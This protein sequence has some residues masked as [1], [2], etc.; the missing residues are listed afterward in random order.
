[1]LGS[2]LIGLIG[3]GLVVSVHE[4][5]HLLAAKAVG[6][7][8]EAYSVGW[9]RKLL[10]FQKGETE[11]RLSAIPLGGYCKMKGEHALMEAWQRDERTIPREEGAFY[12]AKPWERIL[13][14]FS[15]PLV[16]VLFAVLVFGIVAWA[17]Y[18]VQTFSNR[19]VLASELTEEAAPADRAG[20]ET[21]DV[22]LAIDGEETRSFREIQEEVTQAPQE[23][24]TVR[25]R[26]DGGERTLE[27]TPTLNRETGAGQIGIYPWIDPVVG[28][29]AEGSAAAVARLRP[30]DRIRSLGDREVQNSIDLIRAL[31]D[32]SGAQTIRYEREG[33]LRTAR[34]VPGE[35]EAGEPSIGVR[36]EPREFRI[37]A[38]GPLRALGSG[39]SRTTETLVLAVRSIG[40]LFAGVDLSQAV[41][42]PVRITYLVGEVA[43]Q[44]FQSGFGQGVVSFFN[45]LSLISVMLFFMNMLPIPVLDGGQILLSAFE[46][47]TRKPLRPRYVYRYQMIGTA[48][49]LVIIAFAFFND[50][51][52]L[53]R[54]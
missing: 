1:M 47:L 44:G 10:S 38:G 54:R 26:R 50:I 37:E 24:L 19:I 5:G 29:V 52:F 40:L 6:I 8:V 45:F 14:L 27:I 9:G 51:L 7:K 32:D 15:G 42:G 35:N 4:F 21:G 23:T 16:N 13:V 53:A 20:L 22:I 12:S 25:V 39:V 11:Y 28:S 18:T 30:G 31:R 49:V 2:I 46:G 34:I 17:G 43:Q 3:L 48:I 33:E 36:F 41:A